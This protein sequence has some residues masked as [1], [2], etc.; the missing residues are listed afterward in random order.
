MLTPAAER[1]LELLTDTSSDFV[2]IVEGMKDVEALQQLGVRRTDML[3]KYPSIVDMADALA[4]R[5]VRRAVVLTDYDRAGRRLARKIGLALYSVGIRVDWQLRAEL[6]RVFRITHVENLHRTV[7]KIER[8]EVHGKNIHRLG[9]I[10][11]PRK[12]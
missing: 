10:P 8:G 2:V 7:E 11:H 5:G 9:K 1:I 12:L 3:N 6:R 4:E